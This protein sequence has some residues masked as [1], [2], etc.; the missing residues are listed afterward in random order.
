MRIID[1]VTE[2]MGVVIATKITLIVA[3]IIVLGAA[4]FLVRVL[5]K[6]ARI[7]PKGRH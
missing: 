4:G 7:T 2:V 3:G 6:R 1:I 5:V